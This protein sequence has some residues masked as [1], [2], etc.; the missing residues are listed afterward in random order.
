M[1]PMKGERDPDIRGSWAAMQRAARKA[2][3]LAIATD[4][5]LYVMRDGRLIDLNPK[6]K[7]RKPRS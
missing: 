6:S 4:T 7:H 2:R 1:N 5:P 3:K